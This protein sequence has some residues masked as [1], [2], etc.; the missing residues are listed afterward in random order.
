M[1]VITVS[2]A[3]F[4]IVFKL[5][6]CMR[7]TCHVIYCIGTSSDEKNSSEP[8]MKTMTPSFQYPGR[9]VPTTS[10]VAES[11]NYCEQTAKEKPPED[12]LAWNDSKKCTLEINY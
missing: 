7:F 9:S 1:V 8:L 12:K 11:M 2:Y 5:H 10:E 3:A 6:S 4:S